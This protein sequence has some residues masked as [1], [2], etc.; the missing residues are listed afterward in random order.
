MI[1]IAQKTDPLDL[2][3]MHSTISSGDAA[4][5]AVSTLPIIDI[6]PWV[7]E[8]DHEG[9]LSTAAAIHA[10]CLEFGFFYLDITSFVAP[11]EPE[12]LS[13]LAR[14]FFALPQDEKDKISV[15]NEDGARGA[16]QSPINADLF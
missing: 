15:N 6:A 11:E 10:A 12:E 1:L 3:L 16:P 14:D 13:R 2:S 4:A 7:D 5:K 8:H 9:R